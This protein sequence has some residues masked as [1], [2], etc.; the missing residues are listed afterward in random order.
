MIAIRKMQLRLR[1]RRLKAQVLQHRDGAQDREAGGAD[2]RDLEGVDAPCACSLALCEHGCIERE[3]RVDVRRRC[4]PIHVNLPCTCDRTG[5]CLLLVTWAIEM[6]RER[7]LLKRR[8]AVGLAWGAKTR[9][10]GV[11]RFAAAV[12]PRCGPT[13]LRCSVFRAVA[14]LAAFAALTALKQAATSQF[15]KRAARAAR[16]TC[17]AR[18]R[19]GAAHAARARLCRHRGFLGKRRRVAGIEPATRRARHCA[20]VSA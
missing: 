16:K 1:K 5:C 20:R 3:A 7:R 19:R 9:S 12:G 6:V 11:L 4:G 17:A 15:T 2:G 8:S 18:R 14:E 10:G 13:A